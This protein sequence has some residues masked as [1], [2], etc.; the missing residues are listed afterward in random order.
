M[1]IINELGKEIQDDD[2]AY[3]S[4]SVSIY[5][6][7]PLIS[8]ADASQARKPNEKTTMAMLDLVRKNNY[9]KTGDKLGKIHAIKFLA[10]LLKI[11]LK[12]IEEDWNKI[13]IS[14]KTRK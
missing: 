3:K 9:L 11:E 1:G 5:K 6:Y 13:N 14:G 7:F 10:W 4:A 2:E 12:D 8:Y